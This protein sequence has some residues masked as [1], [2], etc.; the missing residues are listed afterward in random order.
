MRVL[1][2]LNL[3]GV[4]NELKYHAE[5][6]TALFHVKPDIKCSKH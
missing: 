6:I 2:L 3:K 1:W 4:L 5:T